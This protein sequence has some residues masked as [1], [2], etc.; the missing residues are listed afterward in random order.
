MFHLWGIG[1]NHKML[2]KRRGAFERGQKCCVNT[3]MGGD[4][5]GVSRQR[6]GVTLEVGAAT[7]QIKERNLLKREKGNG[8]EVKQN[9]CRWSRCC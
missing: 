3:E 4:A 8:S 6:G 9:E 5:T 7:T 2:I 1:L